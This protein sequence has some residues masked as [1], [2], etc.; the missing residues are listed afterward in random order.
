VIAGIIDTTIVIH[1]VRGEP[2]ALA[3]LSSLHDPHGIAPITWI[4]VMRGEN[5]KRRH[6]QVKGIL[7]L[8]DLVYL[9]HSDQQWVMNAIERDAGM[10]VN[11]CMIAAV[12]A[13]LNVPVYTHNLGD[14]RRVLPH[15]KVIRPYQ[16]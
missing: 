6:P 9:E 13:R 15:W 10:Q 3:W 11:D 5:N 7:N 4:E 14:M 1:L 12:A 8:F 16:L 2:A